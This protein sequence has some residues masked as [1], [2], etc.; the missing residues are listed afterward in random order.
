MTGD[1]KSIEF[2]FGATT[3]LGVVVS[4]IVRPDMEAHD[5]VL[6]V[7]M[8]QGAT[9]VAKLFFRLNKDKILNVGDSLNEINEKFGATVT[10]PP[11]QFSRDQLVVTELD[12]NL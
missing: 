4:I 6:T 7:A 11:R 3:Y 2:F 8:L 12:R 9:W 10:H 5:K 1:K